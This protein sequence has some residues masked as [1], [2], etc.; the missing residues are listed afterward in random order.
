M[1][2]RIISALRKK[3]NI[4]Q[5]ELA[6]MLS[7]NT[8]TLS[9]WENGHFEPKASMIKRLCEALECTEIELL[10]GPN[11]QTWELKLVVNKTGN[12]EGGTLDMTGLATATLEIG[13]LSMGITL[14]APFA[15]WED[16]TKFEELI[17]QLRRKRKTGLRTRREDWD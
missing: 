2:G 13:D 11:S 5:E 10:N 15:L 8:A 7:I 17:E 16:D 1:D 6:H 12:T 4:N 14:S 9:R 3:K